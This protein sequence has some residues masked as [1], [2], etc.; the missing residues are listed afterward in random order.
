MRFLFLNISH[1]SFL[2]FTLFYL[3]PK[4]QRYIRVINWNIHKVYEMKKLQASI[5]TKRH[6]ALKI[7]VQKVCAQNPRLKSASEIRAQNQRSK[8][9]FKQYAVGKQTNTNPRSDSTTKL[10]YFEDNTNISKMVTTMF[11]RGRLPTL[12]LRL[13]Q[14]Q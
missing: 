10:R 3:F 4:V 5:I 2:T 7:C 1:F 12:M 14:V 11:S 9:A 8:S 6:N 13:Q